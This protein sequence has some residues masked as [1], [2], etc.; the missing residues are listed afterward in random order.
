MQQHFVRTTKAN[1]NATQFK[2]FFKLFWLI[3]VVFNDISHKKQA[4]IQIVFPFVVAYETD[5]WL[6]RYTMSQTICSV[7]HLVS[8][9][10]EI[11]IRFF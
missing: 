7:S 11:H 3:F 8:V 5:D 4:Q 1:D 6:D 10:Y 2:R 9:G